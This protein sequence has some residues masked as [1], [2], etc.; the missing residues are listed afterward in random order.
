MRLTLV[1]IA[2]VG[3]AYAQDSDSNMSCVERLQ[4][5]AYPPLADSHEFRAE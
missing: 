4:V 1:C 5:P 2:L 3:I